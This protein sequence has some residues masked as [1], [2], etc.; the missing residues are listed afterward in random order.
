MSGGG[1]R[2]DCLVYV[3]IVHSRLGRRAT[4]KADQLRGMSTPRHCSAQCISPPYQWV[5]DGNLSGGSVGHGSHPAAAY[6][7]IDVTKGSI[8]G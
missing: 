1:V 4:P 3:R 5:Q 6:F 2:A 8:P 7:A